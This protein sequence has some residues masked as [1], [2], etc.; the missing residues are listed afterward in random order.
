MNGTVFSHMWN[1]GWRKDLRV[2]REPLKKG[3]RGEKTRKGNRGGEYN[4][5]MLYAYIDT[6]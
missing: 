1:L 6:S 3:K 4:Q 2:K 5:S